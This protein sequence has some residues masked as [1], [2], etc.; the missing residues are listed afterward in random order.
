MSLKDDMENALT[1]FKKPEIT[2]VKKPETSIAGRTIVIGQPGIQSPA[3]R[4]LSRRTRRPSPA[5]SKPSVITNLN[6]RLTED[7]MLRPAT[8][9]RSMNGI[10]GGRS[11]LL[12]I[13]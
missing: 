2:V 3:E 6:N 12:R 8:S 10:L 7:R 11:R 4:I 13:R 1:V 9:S 5:A